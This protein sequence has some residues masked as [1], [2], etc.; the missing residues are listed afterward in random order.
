MRFS[1][2]VGWS[3]IPKIVILDTHV[4]ANFSDRKSNMQIVWNTGDYLV[5]R[6][7]WI[8]T[9]MK[10]WM[11][12]TLPWC[13]FNRFVNILIQLICVQGIHQHR[14]S[15]LIMNSHAPCLFKYL[16][17]VL[18]LVGVKFY[19]QFGVRGSRLH[20]WWLAMP[21]CHPKCSLVPLW[22]SC[23]VVDWHSCEDNLNKCTYERHFSHL[24]VVFYK[25]PTYKVPTYSIWTTIRYS[26]SHRLLRQSK[27]APY[28][29]KSSQSTQ[30]MP[31]V[32][33]QPHG[34]KELD[35]W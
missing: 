33:V 10:I 4:Y 16:L 3:E 11:Q 1:L 23:R 8:G 20:T 26:T 30:S 17:I 2:V 21:F 12:F 29:S 19:K 25:Y 24:A 5:R 7:N 31:F 14:V 15:L 22:L 28:H 32:C 9:P 34:C 13:I 18:V 27:H 6:Q 35:F